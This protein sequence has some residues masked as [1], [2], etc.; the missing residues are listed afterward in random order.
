MPI[1]PDAYMAGAIP[2]LSRGGSWLPDNDMSHSHSAN[3]AAA[4][5]CKADPSGGFGFTTTAT[6]GPHLPNQ[7]YPHTAEPGFRPGYAPINSS[8]MPPLPVD[9]KSDPDPYLNL[10][11]SVY[12]GRNPLYLPGSHLSMPGRF[13]FHAPFHAGPMMYGGWGPHHQQRPL[14]PLATGP[15]PASTTQ[16]GPTTRMVANP[17]VPVSRFGLVVGSR[18]TT[19]HIPTRSQ[20]RQWEEQ[21]GAPRPMAAEPVYPGQVGEVP[22]SPSG[23][24]APN[25]TTSIARVA[26][27]DHDTS[28]RVYRKRAESL[29]TPP[30]PT[31]PR[32][33]ESHVLTEKKKSGRKRKDSRSSQFE[34]KGKEKERD[35]AHAKE[36]V[37]TRQS[38]KRSAEHVSKVEP[39]VSEGMYPKARTRP[40][41]PVRDVSARSRHRSLPLPSLPSAAAIPKEPIKT[42][43]P[44][45]SRKKRTVGS[46]SDP[47][48]TGDRSTTKRNGAL[49]LS[50]ILP[51][52]P[53][54]P[55]ATPT[56]P[57][58]PTRGST[59]GYYPS[60]PAGPLRT[61][62]DAPPGYIPP[63][64]EGVYDRYLPHP[65]APV[66]DRLDRHWTATS[67]C[68]S[69]SG[70]ETSSHSPRGGH[71]VGIELKDA[72][73]RPLG[74]A[75]EVRKMPDVNRSGPALARYGVNWERKDNQVILPDVPDGPRWDVARPPR[76]AEV[77]GGGWWESGGDA[78]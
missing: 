67:P 68:S 9:A 44:L 61:K 25:T 20:G 26:A 71:L 72:V 54:A 15:G 78:R 47:K 57:R 64:S 14:V 65:A 35:S 62:Y 49:S 39:S 7:I 48:S 75:P 74:Y 17:Q 11:A 60:H 1:N 45:S 43:L 31:P 66:P 5:G 52:L 55:T 53:Q 56:Q 6:A 28:R 2:G 29:S 59:R 46:R 22:L 37:R 32:P 13:G 8:P 50:D 21:A 41:S 38:P 51:S 76:D 16:A 73:Y 23:E 27:T 24:V 3:P 30:L 34:P 63:M 19:G 77:R 36:S 4:I 42:S 40:S 69:A 18:L 70:A 58:Q 33:K 10:G 12:G